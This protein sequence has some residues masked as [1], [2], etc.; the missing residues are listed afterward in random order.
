M[1]LQMEELEVTAHRAVNILRA[2]MQ[3]VDQAKALIAEQKNQIAIIEG[4]IVSQE[5]QKQK[6]ETTNQ[7]LEA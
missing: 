6:L 7:R 4:I 3:V 1:D 5:D 2:E